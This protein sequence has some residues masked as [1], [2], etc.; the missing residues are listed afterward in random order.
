MHPYA[1][2]SS[3]GL[4]FGA[5]IIALW[6]GNLTMLLTQP[7]TAAAWVWISPAL[8]LQTFLHTGLFITAHDAMHG[9]LTRHQRWNDFAGSVCVLLYALF[10]FRRLRV[11]HQK[12]H[13]HPAS[14]TDPD[15][16]DGAHAGFWRWYWH[17]MLTYVTWRQLLGMALVFNLLHHVLHVALLNLLLGWIMPALLSTLQ[18]FYFGTFLPHREP[19]GGYEN[20]HHARSNAYRPLWSFLSCYHFG[21]HLEHHEFPF[22]PWWRLPFVRGQ[23]MRRSN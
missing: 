2:Q 1:T 15:F 22:V 18:L 20:R 4:L 12:H 6:F 5:M 11:E 7:V 16:H 21:Y 9:T 14:A 19:A 23:E 3:R 10:S 8:L 13:A 17:F